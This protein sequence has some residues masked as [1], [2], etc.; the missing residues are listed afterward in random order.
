MDNKNVRLALATLFLNL[1]V[2]AHQVDDLE[3]NAR[4]GG[5]VVQVVTNW[6]LIWLDDIPK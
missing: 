3:E 2:A 5:T 4:R 6:L 1:A